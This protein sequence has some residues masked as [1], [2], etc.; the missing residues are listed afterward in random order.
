[1]SGFGPEP[2]RISLLRRLQEEPANQT[3]WNEFVARYGP[4]IHAWCR[5]WNVQEA[6]AEDVT[7]MVLLRLAEKMRT[8]VYDPSRSF[9]AWLKTLTQHAW[10]DLAEHR[11][12]AGAGTG[13][14]SQWDTLQTVP[15]RD[16]LTR[17][18]EELFDLELLELAAT[19]VRQRVAPTTWEAFRLTAMD[20][21]SGSAAAAQLGMPVGSVFKAKSNVLKLLQE[22]MGRLE[23]ITPD[24]DLPVSTTA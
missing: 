1:M 5:R 12:R 18:L 7:Q 22:E 6:D 9:R 16:D 23:R 21:L 14:D 11:R 24:D 3:A 2:T 4:R 13:S 8:F 17:Q 19:R 10:S 15:A 20:G